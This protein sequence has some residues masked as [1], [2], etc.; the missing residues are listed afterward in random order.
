MYKH[1]QMVAHKR[2][3]LEPATPLA[4]SGYIDKFNQTVANLTYLVDKDQKI[5]GAEDLLQSKGNSTFFQGNKNE[6]ISSDTET[7]KILAREINGDQDPEEVKNSAMKF[8]ES[9]KYST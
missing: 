6:C 5:G 2:R 8:A 3:S 4:N 7:L 1:R 9:L